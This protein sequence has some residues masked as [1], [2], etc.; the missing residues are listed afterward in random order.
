MSQQN[1]W[2]DYAIH[3]VRYNKERTHIEF[4]SAMQVSWLGGFGVA[5]SYHR[6]TVIDM[7]DI[8]HYKFATTVRQQNGLWT[9]GPQVYVVTVNGKKYLRTD[10]NSIARDN[11]ENL[12]E[13]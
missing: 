9:Q 4:V 1:K 6:Q 5:Q 10:G 7:I 2:A 11:L 8:Q 12:P 3:A 13:F